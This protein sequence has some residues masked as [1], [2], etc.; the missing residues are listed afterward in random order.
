MS[1][2]KTHHPL[3]VEIERLHDALGQ[4]EILVSNLRSSLTASHE[5]VVEEVTLR[6]GWEHQY[7][8]AEVEISRLNKELNWYMNP[9]P[10]H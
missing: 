7:H 5:R 4:A 1:N 8:N 10:I 3:E 9:F 2:D 6:R